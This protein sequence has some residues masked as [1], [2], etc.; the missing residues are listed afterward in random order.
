MNCEGQTQIPENFMPVLFDI[1]HLV[2]GD[3]QSLAN[4]V[5]VLT[6]FLCAAYPVFIQ[7]VPVLHK[8]SCHT[9][10]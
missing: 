5:S 1:R 10:A 9:V 8:H 6:V 3:V 4:S 7:K 2:E